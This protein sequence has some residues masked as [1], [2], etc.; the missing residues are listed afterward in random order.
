MFLL[1]LRF[2][3][4]LRDF[5]CL[6]YSRSVLVFLLPI[7]K[8]KFLSI[9]LVISSILFSKT[10]SSLLPFEETQLQPQYL[11]SLSAEDSSLL[12]FGDS[13]SA[14]QPK[15]GGRAKDCKVFPGDAEWP[16]EAAWDVL[17]RTLGG[18]LIKTVPIAAP[19]YNG[20]YY[21][22]PSLKN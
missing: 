16:S 2:F 1:I 21:V 22:R 19:C 15:H 8:M 7:P 17:N 18:A 4:S 3:F 10:T 6:S 20:P 14:A 13:T 5:G 12:S 9:S 11:A